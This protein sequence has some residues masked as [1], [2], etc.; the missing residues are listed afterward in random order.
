M[1]GVRSVR[2]AVIRQPGQ[3]CFDLRDSVGIQEFAQVSGAEQ[4]GQ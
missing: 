1:D 4:F 3:F 2:V